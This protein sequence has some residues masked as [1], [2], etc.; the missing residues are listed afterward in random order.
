MVESKKKS[1]ME[2]SK[3]NGMGAGGNDTKTGLPHGGF[4]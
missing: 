1:T 2:F 3:K 4:E